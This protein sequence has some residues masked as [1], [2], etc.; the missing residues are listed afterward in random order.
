MFPCAYVLMTNKTEESYKRVLDELKS[1][2]SRFALFCY[3]SIV[4]LNDFEAAAINAYKYHFP[5][6]PSIIYII[7]VG[8]RFKI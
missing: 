3:F 6:A 7:R 5:R 4:I 8:N 1:T 2:W